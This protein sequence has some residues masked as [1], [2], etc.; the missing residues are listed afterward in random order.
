MR[1]NNRILVV[2][3]T[4]D[5]IDWLQRA[6]PGRVLFLTD[7]SARQQA[8]EPAPEAKDELLFEL[9][10]VDRIGPALMKHLARWNIFLDAVTCFDCESLELAAL[11]A[12]DLSLPFSSV[13]SIRICRDKYAMSG[14]WQKQ[15]LGIPRFTLARTAGEATQFQ[16]EL[17]KPCVLKPV[18]GSGSELVFYSDSEGDCRRFAR[19][20]LD[21]IHHRKE[22]RLYSSAVEGFLMEEFVPGT[23]YSCDFLLQGHEVKI[24]RFS[25]KI[26][27]EDTP[28]GTTVG[29]ALSTCEQEG[30]DGRRLETLLGEAAQALG[31][32]RAFCMVDFLGCD[33]RISLLELS[34][35]PGGDCLP[36]LLRFAVGLDVLKLALDFAQNLAVEV[37]FLPADTHHV[38]LRLHAQQPGRIVGISAWRLREDPRVKDIRLIRQIGHRVVLPPKDYDSWYLGHVLF[39]PND[40]DDIEG[41][42]QA[43]RRLLSVE[44]EAEEP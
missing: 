16:R 5:Y 35:R 6:A 29:Y 7:P 3:T 14:R 40:Q 1:K 42:C 11:L 32:T 33:G 13:E 10:R 31:L 24:L 23:E 8:R 37:P 15:G 25:R 19:L 39:V 2:G 38:G 17:G 18:S 28:F 44:I 4:S 27:A 22:N 21:G 36:Y 9:T 34:P 12:E 30:I 20:L 43:L 41:Q 26:K